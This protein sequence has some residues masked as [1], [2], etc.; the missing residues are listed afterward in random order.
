MLN[1]FDRNRQQVLDQANFLLQEGFRVAHAAKHAVKPRHGFHARANLVAGREQVF[2]RLLVAEL[3]FVRQNRGKLSL[4]LLADID[5]KR[6]PNVVIKRR[7]NNLE[8]TMRR[9]RVA[10][11]S[12]RLSRGVPP[13]GRWKRLTPELSLASPAPPESKPHIPALTPCNDPDAAPSSKAE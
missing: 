5:D 10:P 8:G 1:G 12:C 2:A 13:A 9:E 4:E 3:R 7:V 11:A 6:R